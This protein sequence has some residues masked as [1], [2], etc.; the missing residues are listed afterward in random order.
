MTAISV[1]LGSVLPVSLGLIGWAS[2]NWFYALLTVAGMILVHGATNAINDYFDVKHEVDT[3]QTATAQ[4][5]EHF[6]ITGKLKPQEVLGFSILLYCIA[7][8]IGVFFAVIR[9]WPI[10]LFAVVGGMTSFF[11]TGGPVKF[12]HLALGEAA[13]FLMWGPLMILASFY[14]QT[15]SFDRAG[16]VLLISI[17]Q[18][19]W[20]LL[21][22]FANNMKDTK[23]DSE[24]GVKTV[25]NL[26]SLRA[27]FVLFIVILF[28]IY[29][30]TVV[31][32]IAGLLPVTAVAV[33]VSF[34][35]VLP[36][37]RSLTREKQVPPDADPRT[38]RVGMIYGIVLI[39][40]LIVSTVFL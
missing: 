2:W 31:E 19:L 8:V 23:H 14:I 5:R 18:G 39:L 34:P 10:V 9:G 28:L 26:L 13:V 16:A 6:I 11:Y 24:T 36:L 35:L 3:P 12:K 29:G 27:T 25:A 21:V 33:L 38:A 20:V 37:V 30:I 1:I 22:L 32:I 7:G 17:P 15:G 40:S 4:Y